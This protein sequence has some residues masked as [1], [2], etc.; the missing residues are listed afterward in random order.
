MKKVNL[1]FTTLSI[2]AIATVLVVSCSKKRIQNPTLNEYDA[3]NTN[4][5]LDS[6]QEEEQEFIIDSAGSCPLVGK[7]GTKICSGKPCLMMPNGDTIGYPFTIKLVELYKPKHMIYYRMPTIAGGNILETDGEIRL[8]AFKG[9]T[10]LLLKPGA[11]Y[12]QIE[13]PNAAPKNNMRVFYGYASS[14]PFVDFTDNPTTAGAA[15]TSLPPVFSVTSYGYSNTIGKLGWINCGKNAATTPSSVLTF[16]STV[17]DLTN[18]PIFV[19]LPSTKTVMQASNFT[20][21][22]IPNGM[23]AKII[24][25]AKDASGNLYS[26][27][28]TITVSSN[29][30]IDITMAQ[31]T[32]GALTTLLDGL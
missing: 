15:T 30:Q 2:V 18:V 21:N 28:Q 13:M 32:D 19:Y 8:R 26:F 11:C 24:A 29:Q 23:T 17:D 3:T 25:I 10:E 20:T 22:P 1:V 7:L 4:S 6:K 16:S 14:S 31:T 5:Y 12:A 9:T 27:D